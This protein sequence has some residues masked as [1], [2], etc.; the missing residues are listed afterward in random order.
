[1]FSSLSHTRSTPRLAAPLSVYFPIP[2]RASRQNRRERR[3]DVLLPAPRLLLDDFGSM[4]ELHALRSAH[5][6]A[7]CA[8]ATRVG[9]SEVRSRQR[10][11]HLA[12][13]LPSRDSELRPARVSSLRYR[14]RRASMS[15]PRK[16][17][18]LVA[19]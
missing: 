2:C 10:A 16:V 14:E 7:D 17:K 3:Y 4:S 13:H 9:V 19:K 18:Q 8:D 5:R 15:G 6:R 1:M 12:M 11:P